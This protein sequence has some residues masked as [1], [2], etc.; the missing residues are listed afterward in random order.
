MCP[1]CKYGVFLF[2]N[3]CVVPSWIYVVLQFSVPFNALISLHYIVIHHWL[4]SWERR[5]SVDLGQVVMLM[6]LSQFSTGST[7]SLSSSSSGWP[8]PQIDCEMCQC[9]WCLT[10][11]NKQSLRT[12]SAT[13]S[14]DYGNFSKPQSN[15]KSKI[16]TVLPY[17]R[18][19]PYRQAKHFIFMKIIKL[20]EKPKQTRLHTKTEQ[21]KNLFFSET[22]FKRLFS[23]HLTRRAALSLYTQR[24]S[25]LFQIRAIYFEET[26]KLVL[27]KV[28]FKS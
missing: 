12:V 22:L 10:R 9:L 20:K 8:V 19:R 26:L 6:G 25:F 27:V 2:W 28:F 15:P 21:G 23:A 7:T 24:N 1:I 3:R 16:A 18:Y 13:P 14:C 4:R 17:L 11:Q 5:S